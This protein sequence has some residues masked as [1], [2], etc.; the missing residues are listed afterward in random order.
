MLT[1]VTRATRITVVLAFELYERLKP[2]WIRLEYDWFAGLRDYVRHRQRR[3]VVRRGHTSLLTLF[4]FCF[5]TAYM[6]D[7]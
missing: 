3:E 6:R 7:I 4:L 5:V 2:L 1:P